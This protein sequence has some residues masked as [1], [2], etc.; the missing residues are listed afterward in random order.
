MNKESKINLLI[1]IIVVGF[2]ISVFYHY[3]QGAYLGKPYP[4][5]TFLFIPGD[6]FNDF[7]NCVRT[8]SDLNPFV[9]GKIYSYLPFSSF[10]FYLFSLIRPWELSWCLFIGSFFIIFILMVKHYLFGLRTKLSTYQSLVIF[11]LVFLTYPILFA[12]DRSNIDLL[13]CTTLLLFTLTYERQKFYISTIFLALA[14]A[15]KPLSMVYAIPY[16]IQNKFKPVLLLIFN[17]ALLTGVSLSLFK[18]GILIET[19]KFFIATLTQSRAVT[20]GNIFHFSSDLHN[21]LI[22]NIKFISS[23]FGAEINLL[24]NPQFILYYTIVAIIIFI[25][26]VIYIW[27][28]PSPFW[29]T[30]ALLTIF[31]ILFPYSTNDYRLTYLFIPL[32]MYLKSNDKS[33]LDMPM[34]IVWGL[35]LI[36]KNYLNIGSGDQ[37]IGMIINP[38]L[39]MSL[40]I[41]LVY[42]RTLSVID[43]KKN[44]TAPNI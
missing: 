32:L 38:L 25:L 3:I 43:E 21:L 19:Q 12:L 7:Y 41:L 11:I 33:R 27:K 4:S 24:G 22:I 23:L 34:I 20:E 16:I 5:N 14:I 17:V 42:D 35:L 1:L 13:I 37:N 15:I 36:P 8:S 6:K 39:L 9:P 18:D 30:V 10:I 31:I 29:K 40:L 28:N 2:S 26:L 44:A